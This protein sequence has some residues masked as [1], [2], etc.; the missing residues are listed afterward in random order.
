MTDVSELVDK[1]VRE[2][3]EEARNGKGVLFEAVDI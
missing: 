3:L 1:R 2:L